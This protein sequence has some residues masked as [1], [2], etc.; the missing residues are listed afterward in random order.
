MIRRGILFF[1][2][3]SGWFVAILIFSATAGQERSASARINNANFILAYDRSG[4]TSLANPNDRYRAEL[5]SPAGRLGDTAMKYQVGDGDW[6]DV[7]TTE[8]KMQAR[9]ISTTLNIKSVH[10]AA[11]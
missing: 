1:V 8:R 3:A 7:F 9:L 2:S 4:N 6:P 10:S 11:P 5:L